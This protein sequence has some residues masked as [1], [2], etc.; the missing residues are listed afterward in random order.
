MQSDSIDSGAGTVPH[1]FLHQS[2]VV[3]LHGFHIVRA[4]NVG[5]SS[6]DQNGSRF[7][8]F[9]VLHLGKG[10]I[11][12]FACVFKAQSAVA[13]ARAAVLDVVVAEEFVPFARLHFAVAEEEDVVVSLLVGQHAEV[14]GAHSVRTSETA[15]QLEFGAVVG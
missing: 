2:N 14:G 3:Q 6:I 11:G 7:F 1:D 15:V 8:F 9:H 13:P 10:S 5:G 4:Q 12:N